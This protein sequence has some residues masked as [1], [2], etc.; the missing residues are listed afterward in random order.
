MPWNGVALPIKPLSTTAGVVI[1]SEKGKKKRVENNNSSKKKRVPEKEKDENDL[2][3]L[4]AP[5]FADITG[6][7]GDTVGELIRTGRGGK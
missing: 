1:Q 4:C 3:A 5:T 7:I 2:C 6:A